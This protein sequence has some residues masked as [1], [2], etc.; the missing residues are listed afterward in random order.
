MAHARFVRLTMFLPDLAD[1]AYDPVMAAHA[2]ILSNPPP[3]HIVAIDAIDVDDY[4][5]PYGSKG[6]LVK[7]EYSADRY[8]FELFHMGYDWYQAVRE[9]IKAGFPEDKIDHF[10]V[11]WQDWEGGLIIKE[12]SI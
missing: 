1:G 2:I 5:I 6:Y 10:L 9:L 3:I 7:Y 11:P 8:M 4:T 12:R